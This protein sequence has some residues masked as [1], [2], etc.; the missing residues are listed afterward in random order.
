VVG[1]LSAGEAVF[2]PSQRMTEMQK[3][4]IRRERATLLR[5]HGVTPRVE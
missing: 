3:A 1:L 2:S 4:H 5:R